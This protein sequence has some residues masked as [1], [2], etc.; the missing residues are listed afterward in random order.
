MGGACSIH[1]YTI[2]VGS[3]D[4]Y[5]KVRIILKC[6]SKKLVVRMWIGFI[7]LTIGTPSDGLLWA[8]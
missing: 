6:M 5:V 2:L 8:R 7:W 3:E 4:L 1:V